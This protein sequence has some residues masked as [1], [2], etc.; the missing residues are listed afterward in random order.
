MTKNRSVLNRRN[1]DSILKMLRSWEGRLTWDLLCD[2]CPRAIGMTPT[3]QTLYRS[4][5]IREAFQEKKALA[6]ELTPEPKIQIR[7]SVAMNRLQRLSAENKAL[8]SFKEQMVEKFVIWQYNAYCRGLTV[9]DLDRPLAPQDL[10]RTD[11]KR[12]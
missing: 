6:K 11:S 7:L 1:I 2:A 9:N 8:Q 3:R 4:A 10:N 5:A 12:I